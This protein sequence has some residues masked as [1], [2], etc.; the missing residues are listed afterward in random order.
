VT[1]AATA[2]ASLLNCTNW[3]EFRMGVNDTTYPPKAGPIW[4]GNDSTQRA[5]TNLIHDAKFAVDS[6]HVETGAGVS[7]ALLHYI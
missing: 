4:P 3:S 6:G 5:V 2:I 1:P 7:H